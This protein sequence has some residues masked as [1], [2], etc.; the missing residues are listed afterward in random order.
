MQDRY[1]LAS[2]KPWHV[3]VFESR[4]NTLPGE[5][6]VIQEPK[7]LTA[8]S[9]RE[10][11]PAYVFFPHWSWIVPEEILSEFECVCF[12]MSDVPYGR[13]GSPLQNLIARG[14]QNTKLT[15]L[16]MVS[17]LDAG[18]VYLKRPLSL[19]G[20]AKDIFQRAAEIGF[21]MMD[22]IARHRPAPVPQQGQPVVF[23]RRT[24]ED[25]L[26]PDDGSLEQVYDQIRMLD[27]PTYPHAFIDHGSFRLEF[28]EAE[29]DNDCVTARVRITRP[30]G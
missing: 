12:H 13:G 18:P 16:R 26:L 2:S 22:E 3:Q 7:E 8:A 5:W 27:A 25:S 9:L 21:D 24:P 4:R 29:L 20:A 11:A 15:A 19:E 1:V 10:F 30:S 6:R 17:E 14:H 23:K 28:E